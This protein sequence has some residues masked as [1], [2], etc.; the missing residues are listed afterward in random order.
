MNNRTHL[1][2]LTLAAVLALFAVS[3][4]DDTSDLA[5]RINGID[6]TKEKLSSSVETIKMQYAAQGRADAYESAEDFEADVLETLIADALLLN[7]AKENGYEVNDET[8]DGQYDAIKDQFGS[9]EE[10]ASALE[11]RG[12]TEESLKDEIR[13]GLSIE[14]M[15]EGEINER[16]TVTKDEIEQFYSDNPDFFERQESVT[17]SHIIV[18]VDEDD[19][20]D[21][22][23]KAR[24][25][26]EAI[27]Q[28]IVDGADFAE[29]ARE[30]SEGPSAP[31]G[32][33]LGSFTRGQMVGPFEE[34]AFSL[35]PGEL[36]DI[37]LTEFGYHII[38]V[39]DRSPAALQPIE[40]V[41][42]QIREYLASISRQ[43]ETKDFIDELKAEATI[44]YFE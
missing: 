9:P 18:T 27:R 16:I 5:V 33:S 10:F 23:E 21:E 4:S 35:Q 36:S 24:E 43:E 11:T 22:K 34:A 12:L 40:E 41:S 37:V 17:A 20:E 25:K 7:F 42:P 13:T 38:L 44:E 39:E 19:G 6:I 30:K 1:L 28:E 8:V 32:G 15:L 29:V 31:S 2:I 26:I 14:S 3:C